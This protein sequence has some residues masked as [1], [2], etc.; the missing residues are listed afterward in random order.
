MPKALTVLL[1]EDE[2]LIKELI[3]DTLVGAGYEVVSAADGSEA[4]AILEADPHRFDVVL[5]DI[6]MPGRVLGWE[7]AHRARELC[8][9]IRVIYMTGDS[10]CDW[11]RLSV[12]GSTIC[13]KPATM[14]SILHMIEQSLQH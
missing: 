6:R 8:E 11:K 14:E 4:I 9:Q 2:W 3:E 7:V 5:T 13:T 1:V 10:G 12:P